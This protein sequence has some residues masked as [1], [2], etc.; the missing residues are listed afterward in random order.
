[1]GTM[2]YIINKVHIAL[3]G[4]WRGHTPMTIAVV[5]SG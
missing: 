3:V 5:G 4:G 2:G 1:V